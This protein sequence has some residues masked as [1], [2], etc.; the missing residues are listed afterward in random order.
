MTDP[1]RVHLR[2]TGTTPMPALMALLESIE[3]A[4]FD[5]YSTKEAIHPQTLNAFVREQLE[6]GINLPPELFSVHRVSKA[7]I[8]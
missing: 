5:N 7:V 8:K 2:V 1:V 6:A 4:G 3:A